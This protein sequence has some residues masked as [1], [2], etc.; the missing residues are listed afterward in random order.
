M[1]FK[2]RYSKSVIEIKRENKPPK[3]KTKWELLRAKDKNNIISKANYLQAIGCLVQ[4]FGGILTLYEG[5]S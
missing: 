1:N 4:L 5:N 3:R 2:Y